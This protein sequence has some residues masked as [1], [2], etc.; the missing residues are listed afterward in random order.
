MT[1]YAPPSRLVLFDLDR[2][3]QIND[4]YGHDVGDNVLMIV[5]EIVKDSLR[6]YDLASRTGGEEFCILLPRTSGEDA[7]N[8]AERL[9]VAFE[10]S[11]L[12]PL[13]KGRITC[14]FGVVQ[15]AVH[16][17]AVTRFNIG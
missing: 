17:H 6:P 11:Y 15:A 2:F 13:P 3:K 5:G 12:D 8:I 16:A 9:R 10:V 14:S 4:D 7:I 1:I